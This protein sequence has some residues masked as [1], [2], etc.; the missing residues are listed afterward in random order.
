MPGREQGA[1]PGLPGGP[2]TGGPDGR[3]EALLA[4]PPLDHG[5]GHGRVPVVV[6][7]GD[8]PGRPA[9]QPRLDARGHQQRDRPG[10]VG[11]AFEQAG[12]VGEPG[13]QLD[14]LGIWPGWRGVG[15]VDGAHGTS[16][17]REG[18]ADRPGR[19]AR[20]S[21]WAEP[22][23]G[24]GDTRRTPSASGRG[25]GRGPG[26]SG[27]AWHR[28]GCR[29]TRR[30]SSRGALHRRLYRIATNSCRCGCRIGPV[31]WGGSAIF[32]PAL[33]STSP[34]VRPSLRRAPD[35]SPGSRRLSSL[36]VVPKGA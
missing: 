10:W 7:G 34:V 27:A 4:E 16:L 2:P 21:G 6:H 25:G 5:Q 30:L 20:L 18:L 1:G 3:V 29:S 17:V 23:A 19:A 32:L 33:V 35:L 14:E 11:W 13:G 26:R 28:G 36:P 8:Q 9:D 15:G 31:G 24:P 22:G 12:L